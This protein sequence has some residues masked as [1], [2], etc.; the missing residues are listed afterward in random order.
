MR[1]DPEL[2][3]EAQIELLRCVGIR[4]ENHVN[5]EGKPSQIIFNDWA[6]KSTKDLDKIRGTVG[7]FMGAI[8]VEYGRLDMRADR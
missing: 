6:D 5:G 8:I 1:V 7:K 3:S 2:F 4:V